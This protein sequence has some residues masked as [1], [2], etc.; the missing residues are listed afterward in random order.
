MTLMNS[1][2]Y[3]AG[4]TVAPITVGLSAG[5]LPELQVRAA[6]IRG[7]VPR[8]RLLTQMAAGAP[9]PAELFGT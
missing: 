7:I 9:S 4:S 2:I 8:F 6:V 3:C 5:G 1:G